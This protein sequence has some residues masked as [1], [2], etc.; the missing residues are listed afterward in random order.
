MGALMGIGGIVLAIP[1]LAILKLVAEEIDVLKPVALLMDK[2]I[3]RK[4]HLFLSKYDRED[5]RLSSL[6]DQEENK[7]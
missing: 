4:R 6:M 5:Y 1:I 7:R 2:D 3:M